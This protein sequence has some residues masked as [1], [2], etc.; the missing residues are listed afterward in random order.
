MHRERGKFSELEICIRVTDDVLSVEE[1][2]SLATPTLSLTLQLGNV[3]FAM[4]PQ[5]D[6]SQW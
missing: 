3:T 4:P 6:P 1:E 2:Y 5:M